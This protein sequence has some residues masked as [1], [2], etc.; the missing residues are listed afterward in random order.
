MTGIPL[1]SLPGLP[2][3]ANATVQALEFG[4][5]VH[6]PTGDGEVIVTVPYLHD[7]NVPEGGDKTGWI[8]CSDRLCDAPYAVQFFRTTDPEY[9]DQPSQSN[10]FQIDHATYLGTL[11]E[12]TPVGVQILTVG[13]VRSVVIGMNM[14][15]PLPAYFPSP[16]NVAFGNSS[17][18]GYVL[19]M[20]LSD[21]TPTSLYRIS[22]QV[23][24][25]KIAKAGGL[26]YLVFATAEGVVAL[27]GQTLAVTRA[28]QAPPGVTFTRAAMDASGRMAA[29]H[30][31]GGIYTNI[32]LIDAGDTLLATRTYPGSGVN[33]IEMLDGAEPV[34]FIGG[35]SQLASGASAGYQRPNL[36]AW[37]TAAAT[38]L[39]DS[40]CLWC[41]MS[42]AAIQQ[43]NLLA[44]SR[45]AELEIS[46]DG[47]SLYFISLCAGGNTV[48]LRDPYNLTAGATY[49][50]SLDDYT[51]PYN[52]QGAPHLLFYARIDLARRN[53]AK[54][55]FRLTRL[56]STGKGNTLDPSLASFA[57]GPKG[58]M[59]I[60]GKAACCIPARDGDPE[61]VKTVLRL[62]CNKVGSY[63]G[64]DAY[65]MH[66]SKDM[67]Y[68]SFWTTLNAGVAPAAGGARDCV[69]VAVDSVQAVALF[70]AAAGNL[71]VTASAVAR[72]NLNASDVYIAVWP[73]KQVTQD[74]SVQF[75]A[76][77]LPFVDPDTTYVPPMPPQ[78]AAP[79][80][81]AAGQTGPNVGGIVA[82]VVVAV[83]VVA[84]A[85][86]AIFIFRHRL[87]QVFVK[88]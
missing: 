50:S 46:D 28:I 19:V 35:F 36:H 57:I 38:P 32:T 23:N 71:T 49:L 60:A 20:R 88:A 2:A 66:V 67:D 62:N 78:V 75:L 11:G 14:P 7:N 70:R 53:I 64:G 12:D 45:I 69:G 59:Y 54:G 58:D 86:I 18:N 83:I 26:K 41:G 63:N 47:T 72:A 82:G 27:N 52:I 6:S 1:K 10:N 31:G 43:Q 74:C 24:S 34:V 79:V 21:M 37:S 29:V 51:S 65:I 81:G 48:Y 40:W 17:S 87:K 30:F 85:A 55:Q 3:M 84:A 13:G 33:D 68:T 9:A 80:D 4:F 22:R 15:G 61:N 44:D 77:T 73:H 25:M 5:G 16:T 8:Q 42:L 39:Q 56:P 76:D